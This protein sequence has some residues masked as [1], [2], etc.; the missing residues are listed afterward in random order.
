VNGP[1][2]NAEGDVLVVMQSLHSQE[3]GRFRL[4]AVH[5]GMVWLVVAPFSRVTIFAPVGERN[6]AH[7]SEYPASTQCV[8]AFTRRRREGALALMAKYGASVWRLWGTMRHASVVHVRLPG[9]LPLAGGVLAALMGRTLLTSV[10]GSPSAH[11]TAGREWSFGGTW[12]WAGSALFRSLTRFVVARSRLAIVTGESLRRSLGIQAV[13]AGQHQFRRADIF[14]RQDTCGGP[15]VQLLYVGRMSREKGTDSLLDA[16]EKLR[17]IDPGY[18]LVLVGEGSGIDVPA[19]VQRRALGDCVEYH[20]YRALRP[21]LLDIYRSSDLLVFPSLHEGI[22][23]VPL[24][25]MSQGLPVV[26]SDPATGDYVEDGRN[27]VVIEAGS[28]DAIVAGVSR[29]RR[30][31]SL[32]RDCI[33]AGLDTA[34]QQCREEVEARVSEMVRARFTMEP[35]VQ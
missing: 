25:A 33:R 4:G 9:H 8:V 23:K 5:I 3:A 34:R 16:F 27:G 24:E 1:A 18:R 22:P 19:E 10:H 14:E 6:P 32:R 30:D 31:A 35:R 20:R 15:V 12:R 26:V 13:V 29:M 2:R 17:R 21:D 28:V 7:D 11:L